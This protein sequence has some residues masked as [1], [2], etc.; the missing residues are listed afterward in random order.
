MAVGKVRPFH[1]L[2][3]TPSSLSRFP[4]L[5]S[6]F[7]PA[8]RLHY[9]PL[10]YFLA[11]SHL[12]FDSSQ[13]VSHSQ[14]G[15]ALLSH[16]F[17]LKYLRH[18]TC[19]LFNG[20]SLSLQCSYSPLPVPHSVGIWNSPNPHG[21][22]THFLYRP[23]VRKEVREVSSLRFIREVRGN[24]CVA[25]ASPRSLD[26]ARHTSRYRFPSSCFQNLSAQDSL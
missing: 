13:L 12:R 26:L 3:S 14:S 8:A 23:L 7:L 5:A 15:N 19:L 2:S 22:G 20:H 18:I 21:F 17:Y 16:K 9:I 25:K 11:K 1:S 4:V 10:F 6:F 24:T